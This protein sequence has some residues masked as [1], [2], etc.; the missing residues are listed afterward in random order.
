MFI[1]INGDKKD[2]TESP[3]GYWFIVSIKH[4]FENEMYQNEITAVKF[5]TKPNNIAPTANQPVGLPPLL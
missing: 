5:C 1:L 3:T 4:I 2:Q